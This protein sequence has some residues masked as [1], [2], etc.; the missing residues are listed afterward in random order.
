MGEKS[1]ENTR[2]R[3]KMSGGSRAVLKTISSLKTHGNK[4]SPKLLAFKGKL[5]ATSP[6]WRLMMASLLLSGVTVQQ[7]MGPEW[8][9][10]PN[11]H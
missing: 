11:S 10:S 5:S 1:K 7:H 6:G 2:R 3:K 4:T 8:K 9:D